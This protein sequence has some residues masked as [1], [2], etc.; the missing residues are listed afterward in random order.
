MLGDHGFLRTVYDNTHEIAP[1]K[2]WR[3]YQPS[4]AHL[5]R[6]AAKGVK[7][8]VNLRGDNPSGFLFLEEEACTR[9]GLQ[10]TN[11]RVYS[12]D[13]PS[14][15][16]LHHARDLFNNI[17]YPAIMHCKSGADRA[18]LMSVLYLFFHE[19]APLDQALEQLSF[20]YGHV[21]AGKTGV[22]DAAFE[23]YIAHAKA[24]NITLTSV[25]AFF[26]WV[27]SDYD[28]AD[29]KAAFRSKGWGDLLTEIIL[30]RE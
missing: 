6:W 17:E 29:V 23:R 16:I 3:T 28:P 1:G 27:E 12:R 24:N 26:D 18:G 4:P 10:L 8:V 22:I 9:L 13:A 14:K 5:E 30:R 21:K 11:F 7:T 25:D 2:M 19:D 15:E 20:K